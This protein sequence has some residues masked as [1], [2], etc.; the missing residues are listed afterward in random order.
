LAA[1]ADEEVF[2]TIHKA[3]QQLL[4]EKNAAGDKSISVQEILLDHDLDNHNRDL[5]YIA[6][7]PLHIL[8]VKL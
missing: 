2:K 6:E 1:P 3:H 7:E 4:K 5:E 8:K